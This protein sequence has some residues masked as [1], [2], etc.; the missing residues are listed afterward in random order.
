MASLLGLASCSTFSGEPKILAKPEIVGCISP[1]PIT[2]EKP[3]VADIELFRPVKK[4]PNGKYVADDK[5]NVYVGFTLE[6]YLEFTDK[7]GRFVTY[8]RTMEAAITHEN[9]RRLLCNK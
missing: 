9:E 8:A 4:L 1:G 2:I 7:L 5:S 3:P 6:G